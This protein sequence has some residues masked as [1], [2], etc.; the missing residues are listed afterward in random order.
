MLVNRNRFVLPLAGDGDISLTHGAIVETGPAGEG[1]LAVYVTPLIVGVDRVVFAV[2]AVD[3][4]RIVFQICIRVFGQLEDDGLPVGIVHIDLGSTSPAV[5][6]RIRFIIVVRNIVAILI[7]RP[8]GVQG[9][10]GVHGDCRPSKDNLPSILFGG[11]QLFFFRAEAQEDGLIHRNRLTSLCHSQY[12]GF[13]PSFVGLSLDGTCAAV[14]VIGQGVLRSKGG[15]LQ[16]NLSNQL[17][18]QLF[19]INVDILRIQ[20]D[21][22]RSDP[23][24]PISQG[25]GV[26]LGIDGNGG[27]GLGINN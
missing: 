7:L 9:D 3:G 6:Y 20:V 8:D 10:R 15:M 19:H 23:R 14:G 25:A 12:G 17:A 21:R 11:D 27:N 5:S 24:A 16:T 13:G 26:V 4:I 2:G 1:V 18:I 22:Y